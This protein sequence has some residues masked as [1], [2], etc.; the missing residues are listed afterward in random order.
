[1]R[2]SDGVTLDGAEV[3]AGSAG[4]VLLHE[5]PSD[6]C[7]WWPYAQALER[8]HVRALMIDLRCF[9]RSG[10]PPQSSRSQEPALDVAAAAAELRREGARTVTVV[11]ASFGGA[12]ALVAGSKL[13]RR[14]DGVVSLSGEADLSDALNVPKVIGRMRVPLLMAVA[15][16][17]GYISVGQARAMVREAGSRHKRLLV[18]PAA[19]GHGTQLLGPDGE[20]ATPLLAVVTR[21]VRAPG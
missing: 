17:D 2:T 5:S 19:D 8:A 4:A 15:P 1:M 12:S 20:D 6:L 11:G 3:G 13:G 14:V 7:D 16:G 9:G 10:C 21:F 18:R